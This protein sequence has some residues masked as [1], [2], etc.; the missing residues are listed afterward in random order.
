MNRTLPIV[1]LRGVIVCIILLLLL[2]PPFSQISYA[3]GVLSLDVNI[4]GDPVSVD[5]GEIL[6]YVIDYSCAG[7]TAG[8][9][10]L[11]LDFPLDPDL[12]F[13]D[14]VTSPGYTGQQVG[15]TITIT[16]DDN[17][18]A[19]GDSAQALIRVRARLDLDGSETI[20]QSVTGTITTGPGG[21]SQS[22]TDNAPTLPVNTPS[23]QWSVQKVQTTPAGGV[24]P[25][26]G[27]QAT[28]DV[29]FC[30]DSATGNITLFNASLVD[31]FPA[32]ATVVDNPDGGSVVG[33]QI[34]WNLGDL[35]ISVVGA[36]CITRTYTLEYPDT[37]FAEGDTIDNTVQGFGTNPDYSTDGV[38]GTNCLDESTVPRTVDAPTVNPITN[39]SGPGQTIVSPGGNSVFR[40]NL[41]LT[42]ANVPAENVILQDSIPDA[43]SDPNLPALDIINI[44]SGTWS[45]PVDASVEF[46]TDNG[47]N[48]TALGTVDG[49]TNVT[50]VRGTDFTTGPNPTD[51]I[52]NVRWVFDPTGTPPSVPAGFTFDALPGIRYEP[53]PNLQP[54]DFG[55]GGTGFQD[56]DNCITVDYAVDGGTTQTTPQQCAST[57]LSEN[58]QNFANINVSKRPAEGQADTIDIE[59]DI[60]FTA[61]IELTQEASG[62]LVNPVI[63]DVLPE[64]LENT[65]FDEV[66]WVGITPA[67]QVTPIVNVTNNGTNDIITVDFDGLNLVPPDVG[68]KRIEVDFTATAPFT[69][70]AG[71]YENTISVVSDSPNQIC[72]T[73]TTTT[74]GSDIDGDGITGEVACEGSTTFNVREA[75]E[76]RSAKWIRSLEGN[77]N[78]VDPAD[79]NIEPNNACPIFTNS[80]QQYTR[81]PCVAQGL[82]TETFE[83]AM[84]VTNTGRTNINEYILYDVLPYIGDTGV[85]EANSTED[86][87]TEFAVR[88][89]GPITLDGANSILL[90]GATFT[91]EY[92]FDR[93]VCR[94]EVSSDQVETG[95]QPGCTPANADTGWIDAAGVGGNWGDVEA[96][97]I[98]QNVAGGTVIA[99]GDTMI[100]LAPMEIIPYDE[101]NNNI[102][103][104]DDPETGEIAWNNFA[105]RF[106]NAASG[107]RLLT[108]EPRK[109]GIIVIQEYSIGNIVWEDNGVGAGG[110]SNDGRINGTEAGLPDITMQLFRDANGNN[111]FDSGVDTLI[112]TDIT[113]ANGYYLFEVDDLGNALTDGTYF[114]RIDPDEFGIGGD[115]IDYVGSTPQFNNNQDN[116]DNGRNPGNVAN[117][118]TQGIVNQRVV[119]SRNGSPTGEADLSNNPA[120]GPAFRGTRNQE[121]ED[122]NL[123]IDFGVYK[124]HAIG[125]RV[126]LDDGAGDPGNYNNGL[127]DA[128]EVG[129]DGVTV[130]LYKDTNGDGVVDPDGT[131][132][133][134]FATTT[135]IDGGYYLFDLLA[136]DQY[137]VQIDP[138]SFEFGPTDAD[139]GPLAKF[140]SSTGNTGDT[141]VDDDDNGIDPLT[142]G[143]QR[144]DGV[145]SVLIDLE[146]DG[147]NDAESDKNTNLTDP[148]GRRTD[149]DSSE[150]TV[151]FGFY[152][153]QDFTSLGNRVWQ[154]DNN[155]GLRDPGEPG[156]EGVTLQIYEDDNGDGIPDD[157]GGDG[158]ANDLIDTQVTDADG[159]YLFD[160]LLPGRYVVIIPATNWTDGG[161]PPLLNFISS[162]GDTPTENVND[163]DNGIDEADYD[164]QVLNG[165]SSGTIQLVP[166]GEPLNDDDSDPGSGS[167]VATDNNSDLT[168]DFGFYRTM[169]LGNLVWRDNANTNGAVP[170]DGIY[171]PAEGEAGIDDVLVELFRDDGDGVFEPGT[172]TGQDGDPIATD[173]TENGGFYLFD[174]LLPGPY[175]V[176]VPLE[177][178]NDTGDPLFGHL[179][180]DGVDG[181]NGDETAVLADDND[182][183]GEDDPDPAS[184]GIVTEQVTLTYDTEPT[185]EALKEPGVDDG[186]LVTEPNSDLTKDFGFYV[187]PLSLGN[188]VW[189]DTNRDGIFDP[190]TESGIDDVTVFLYEDV[191]DDSSFEPGSDDGTALQTDVTHDGG[192]YIFDNLAP[193]NYFV[194]IAPNEFDTGGQLIS[195]I[196]TTTGVTNAPIDDSNDNGSPD[197]PAN[198]TSAGVFTERVTL[199]LGSAPSGEDANAGGSGNEGP[200]GRGRNGETEPNSDLT[201]DFGFYVPLSIGNRVWND[202]GGSGGSGG[203]S[204]NGIQDGDEQGIPGIVIN[205]YFDANGDGT[206]D[207]NG[208]DGGPIATT[209]T[210]ANGY[211]IFD[212]LIEGEYIVEV[213]TEN[214]NEDTDTLWEAFSSNRGNSEADDGIDQTDKGL[215]APN[216]SLTGVR[217]PQV[218]LALTTEP[219]PG[220]PT[221]DTDLGPEG[222]GT[223]GELDNNSDLTVDFGFVV[224]PLSI[225]NRVWF[226]LNN[227]GEIDA[228][229]GFVPGAQVNLFA[230]VN[231]DGIAQAGEFVTN[232]NTDAN[233]YYLFDGL[234]AGSYIVVVDQRNFRTGGVLVDYFSTTDTTPPTDN[235]TDTTPGT[236]TGTNTDDG[237]DSLTP[238]VGGIASPVIE[239]GPGQEVDTET[240]KG[241]GGDGTNGEEVTNSNL[242][243]DFGFYKPMAIGNR[244]WF[245]VDGDGLIGPTENG[246]PGVSVSLFE[247]ENNDGVPDGAV[248]TE[249]TDAGGYY[250]FDNLSPGTYRVRINGSNF[251]A[252][253]A[254]QGTSSTVTG[255]ANP[256][257]QD[258]NDNGTDQPDEAAYIANGVLSET[259]TL[260]LDGQPTGESDLSGNTPLDGPNSIGL[261]GE[262]NNNS[263]ISID[264]GF[265]TPG[266]MSLGNRVWE[267]A[268]RDG[269]ING[270]ETGISN[271]AVSLYRDANGD[272]TPDGAAI[273]TTA[274]DA[275][276]YYLF[277]GLLPGR[278]IVGVDADNTS[279]GSP[280]N[281][282]TNTVTATQNDTP[283]EDLYTDPADDDSND[284]A[285]DTLDTTFGFLSNTVE[286]VLNGERTDEADTGTLGDGSSTPANSDLTVDFGFYRPQSIGNRV[287]FD[288]N[289]DGQ[290]DDTESGAANVAVT[291]FLDDN[292]NNTPDAGEEVATEQ[293]DSNGYYLFD[294]LAPGSYIVRVDP[295]NF[296]TGGPLEG[297]ASSTPTDN[298]KTID[299]NDNG[300]T[301][302]DIVI[303]GVSSGVIT[304][305]LGGEPTGEADLS[306]NTALDGPQ[307]RGTNGEAD[308]DSNLTVDFGFFT[309]DLYSIGNRVWLDTS[310]DGLINGAESGI[311]GVGVSLYR[312]AN[313]DGEPDGDAIASENTDANGYYLFDGLTQG[314]YLVGIDAANFAGT[315]PL[316]GF[317][318]TLTGID[319]D[320]TDAVPPAQVDSNDNR[321]NPSRTQPLDNTFG[322]LSATV[323]LSPGGSPTGEADLSGNTPADGPNSRGTNG[324]TD[325][326][327]DLTIDFGFFPVL[328]LGNRVWFDADNSGTINGSEP[329]IGGVRVNLYRD[330]N[331]D[332]VPDDFDG[333]GTFGDAGDVID[334]DTTD[335]RGYYLFNNVAPGN[336]IVGIDSSNFDPGSPLDQSASSTGDSATI[337]DRDDNGRDAPDA[338]GNILSNTVVLTLNGAPTGETDTSG[339]IDD[340]PNFRG[341]NDESDNNS[342]L[343]VDFGFVSNPMSIGNRVWL[344]DGAGGGDADNGEI[345][346]GEQGIAGV[347]VELFADIDGDGEPDNTLNVLATDTTDANGYYLFDGLPPGRYVVRIAPSNFRSGGVL[348]GL[349]SSEGSG[350]VDESS[351]DQGIDNDD[352]QSDGI[353]S[354]SILLEQNNEP[355]DDEDDLSG[356][357]ADGPES[358]GETGETDENSNLAVDFGFTAVF[359]WGDAP[360]GGGDGNYGTR[361]ANN[362]PN[363][364]I[365]PLLFLGGRVD[366]E[367]NGNPNSDANGD[368]DNGVA[369]DDEDGVRIEDFVAGT[370]VD[371]EVNVF[372]NTGV[373]ATLIGWFDWNGDGDFDADEAVSVTVGS[374]PNVQVVS[375]PVD[376]PLEADIDTDGTTYAR[377]RLTTD[378]LDASTP[379]GRAND[380]EVED[381]LITV[382]PPGVAITKTDGLA[383]I[384]R[385]QSTTYTITVTNSGADADNLQFVDDIPTGD[386]DGF[387][388]DSVEWECT[389]AD[390]ASCIVG[391]PE[392]TGDSGTGDIDTFISL[393]RDGQITFTI[394]ATLREGYTAGTVINTAEIVDGPSST[395]ENGVIF[396]PPAG[397]KVGVVDG[398]TLI[399]WTQTWFNSGGAPQTA[400]VRD[401]IADDQ[402]Y[403]GNLECPAFGS[404]TTNRCEF[405]GGEVVW[406]GVIFPGDSNRVEISFDVIVDGPGTYE[407]TGVLT[408]DV[409]ASSTDA[410]DSATG[411]VTIDEDD[412]DD[413]EEDDEDDNNTDGDSDDDDD[414]GGSGVTGT[415]GVLPPP[416]NPNLL[417]TVVGDP[418]FVNTGE[419]V[420]WTITVTNT[421]TDPATTFD[422]TSAIPPALDLT[423]AIPSIGTISQDGRVII[424][425]G[426]SLQPGESLTVIL[427]TTV[428]TDL[429][430]I[431]L[432]TVQVALNGQLVAQGQVTV[433]LALPETGEAV[434][435]L[436]QSRPLWWPLLIMAVGGGVGYGLYRRHRTLNR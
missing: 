338:N 405:V 275:S 304:I 64:S 311:A 167:G 292:G 232:V 269:L 215:D 22:V 426:V 230:D 300:L 357:P 289:D 381:Y 209:S 34:T 105:Q 19:D 236:I 155:N 216:P 366:N 193:G 328:S 399:R 178:F 109:V 121:D 129:I 61:I 418:P 386:P 162:T 374:D 356:N 44:E 353:L 29:S 151:D 28:Y 433:V 148:D 276:G 185:F 373:D 332:G 15:S 417:V 294:D 339:S 198:Y 208:A 13:I 376:V 241:P 420:T 182:D 221:D 326:N 333:N 56:Y 253:G 217:S 415:T 72:Q 282:F 147:E 82:P 274:T 92:S 369:D 425:Q 295:T 427:F 412:E 69:A 377:F 375:L 118:P 144:N 10:D 244:V 414:D 243:L 382:N 48:W 403:N 160:E 194:Q 132:G 434:S 189:F 41:N 436:P 91:I 315:G 104:D 36:S 57:R 259:V 203:I 210:D 277:E 175:F 85:A 284:N 153:P 138:V 225:G 120:D 317:A 231:G 60:T 177:N 190:A 330:A 134:P 428:R 20:A 352:P 154:D 6:V 297:T 265:S 3:T 181:D 349:F 75:A 35:D 77:L 329:G 152:R 345:D 14:V 396:D 251:D 183:N 370:T 116:N 407:N 394:T 174:G 30:S 296:G 340:G 368:D 179:S 27:T 391:E 108:A 51:Y 223:N 73:G 218:T 301:P 96:F 335:G 139:D 187:P 97:R 388:P 266:E 158:L 38:C 383:S 202:N 237:I 128:G 43:V 24:A 25:A 40:L 126:W 39:K 408:V 45:A 168:V 95:W 159:H 354:S 247:D 74:D 164:A 278:Y 258:N 26:A 53:N 89:T 406:Q 207:P 98:R 410:T 325:G 422:L 4:D 103:T 299:D 65:T 319:N 196:S 402:T 419:D 86:R 79:P 83:Y 321:S 224:P 431:D 87:D 76:M 245:D 348:T 416:S 378:S 227:N 411:T 432:I 114:V 254:L 344:D 42:E 285:D 384:V 133:G 342:D 409:G 166:Q 70:A 125:N 55:T 123:T 363:H 424:L 23:A 204:D 364:R 380:G 173:T 143:D 423:L 429:T 21:G 413:N 372:N 362:G 331:N 281:G 306:N 170:G 62:N 176:R 283:P 404:S 146:Q 186:E 336:Y 291:L 238:Q 122:S 308:A 33:N 261:N 17:D 288:L 264:F 5:T 2:T 197:D 172:G 222:D 303:D 199:S 211:Y 149:V 286:L 359:D 250:L 279:T 50:W 305:A 191:D 100:W 385:G 145:F 350:P 200:D 180:S 337:D 90:G 141:E 113:D 192:Y 271:V 361:E 246:A 130:N 71:A 272:G 101:D 52:T 94:N 314:Q 367:M 111:N 255:T 270:T 165:I 18:F 313:G 252:G 263:D 430:N 169:S 421:G 435:P 379:T 31:T 54:I 401:E 47:S 1:N 235:D 320:P 327:S 142:E 93:N 32:G 343:T 387:E 302:A 400:T 8:C 58:P 59:E 323:T 273:A 226:D 389:A 68:V 351:R 119:L 157:P 188:R 355:T 84:V 298:D 112:A 171:Q 393:P 398:D 124:P 9:G 7:I 135:T 307:S 287:W 312:D 16:D 290:I 293:T 229:E 228:T 49:S 214:F 66:R 11:T 137:I 318:S 213:D 334:T 309:S 37:D 150:L 163:N 395:D 99:P 131:D 156:I 106:T 262:T 365:T 268:N 267:D 184:N 322:M 140:L 219:A 280:L 324:E 205:L 392:G 110:I 201:L 206:V 390:G 88:L 360:D 242:T 341:I 358:R 115:L 248:I 117:Y 46:S 316:A 233:G 161:T 249:T 220:N 212:D 67:E 346:G 127:R 347:V 371:V 136:P 234:T 102:I 260:S 81:F 107:R 257:A 310:A 78:F 195:Y 240:D 397:E 12:E 256:P 63:Q 239:L 80:G